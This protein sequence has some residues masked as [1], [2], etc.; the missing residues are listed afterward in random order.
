MTHDSPPLQ[1]ELFDAMHYK[2]DPGNPDYLVMI[3]DQNRRTLAL[4]ARE[5]SR[6]PQVICLL[7][8]SSCRANP[9]F[10]ELTMSSKR[11]HCKPHCDMRVFGGMHCC[12]G[13]L[14]C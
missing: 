6:N 3:G 9:K 2:F 14:A 11:S 12:S 13:R 4:T 7:V 10:R 5:L 8:G 1:L